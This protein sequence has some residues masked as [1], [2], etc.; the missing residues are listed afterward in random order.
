[1]NIAITILHFTMTLPMLGA[2]ALPVP[3]SR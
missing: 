1:M 3:W 2:I